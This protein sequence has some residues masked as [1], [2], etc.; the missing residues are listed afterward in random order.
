L[1]DAEDFDT[2]GGGLT[3]DEATSS[4][5]ATMD[6]LGPL[7]DAEGEPP[8]KKKGAPKAAAAAK[9][10]GVKAAAPAPETTEEEPADD[11]AGDETEEEEEL[12]AGA[13]VEGAGDEDDD[14]FDLPTAVQAALDGSDEDLLSRV[15]IEHAG[16]KKPLKDVLTAFR[17]QPQAEHEINLA[18]VAAQRATGAMQEYERTLAPAIDEIQNLHMAMREEMALDNQRITELER[19]ADRG[20]DDANRE[21]RRLY[22]QQQRRQGL[23]GRVQHTLTADQR[24]RAADAD[25][26]AYDTQM[27]QIA[28][29]QRA[30]PELLVQAKAEA[31]M[32]GI[33][34]YLQKSHGMSD[35]Q[36]NMHGKD[37]QFL[38]MADKAREWDAFQAKAAAGRAKQREQEEKNAR[39][40][41]GAVVRL[42]GRAR[43]SEETVQRGDYDKA[44]AQA[45]KTGSVRD[46]AA[47]FER[48]I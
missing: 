23:L 47:A 36:I 22:K 27:E 26:R 21:L 42:P 31:W 19:E 33:V 7:E 13:A 25:R 32:D 48:M 17:L 10:K 44:L 24:R 45:R 28:M 5:L 29:L 35:Q 38:L 15:L 3:A 39:K 46:A 14:E 8:P 16:E 41:G 6:D 18:R 11:D 1:S 43:R 4:F 12:E 30:K 40:K 2:E 20:D 37:H 9:P 34:G